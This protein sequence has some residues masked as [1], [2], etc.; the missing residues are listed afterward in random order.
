MLPRFVDPLPLPPVLEPDG[1]RPDPG[2]ATRQVDY[3]RIAMREAEC[4]FHRDVQPAKVWGYAG[5]ASRSTAPRRVL[6]EAAAGESF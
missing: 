1:V 5:I 6:C 4:R 2:D 3:Y